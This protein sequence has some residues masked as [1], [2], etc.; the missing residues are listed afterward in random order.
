[1]LLWIRWLLLLFNEDIVVADAAGI[2]LVSSGGTV[3]PVTVSV[4][5]KVLTVTPNALLN[6]K[7]QVYFGSCSR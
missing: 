1:M 6:A 4:S 3:V 7:T 5:G 2:R